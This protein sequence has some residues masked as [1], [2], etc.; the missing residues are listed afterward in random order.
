MSLTVLSRFSQPYWSLVFFCIS[1]ACKFI[2]IWDMHRL[3]FVCGASCSPLILHY[4]LFRYW[5]VS[6]VWDKYSNSVKSEINMQ[7]LLEHFG[8]W[9]NSKFPKFCFSAYMFYSDHFSTNA[10]VITVRMHLA[11]KTDK[12]F[13]DPPPTYYCNQ[14]LVTTNILDN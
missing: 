14:L 6:G 9:K 12:R 11:I 4:I 13:D 10:L 1:I 2:D 7:L 8:T 5:R 3:R